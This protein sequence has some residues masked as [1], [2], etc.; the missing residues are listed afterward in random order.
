MEGVTVVSSFM[1]GFG[2]VNMLLILTCISLA[3]TYV[4]KDFK[5]YRYCMV[6]FCTT[7]MLLPMLFFTTM[8]LNIPWQKITIDETV[9]AEEFFENYKILDVEDGI[10]F[11]RPLDN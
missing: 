3:L 2:H 1:F 7:I 11:V 6:A 8:N 5:D 9:I 4:F 10:Y